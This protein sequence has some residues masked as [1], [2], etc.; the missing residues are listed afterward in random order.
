MQLEME[1]ESVL[2]VHVTAPIYEYRMQIS[3]EINN[4]LKVYDKYM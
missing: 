1:Q 4:V 3:K 2:P